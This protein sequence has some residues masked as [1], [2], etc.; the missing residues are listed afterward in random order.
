MT[1]WKSNWPPICTTRPASC[2]EIRR[3][4]KRSTRVPPG[5]FH[6]RS[7]DWR[8]L[9]HAD[10]TGARRTACP[11]PPVSSGGL[12]VRFRRRRNLFAIRSTGN[13][14]AFQCESSPWNR[15]SRRAIYS[16]PYPQN[17]SRN[18]RTKRHVGVPV[19]FSPTGGCG[20]KRRWRRIT[21]WLSCPPTLASPITPSGHTCSVSALAAAFGG[22]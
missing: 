2:L 16:R 11:F 17:V 14:Y 5:W 3:M 10:H 19:F 18:Y 6:R 22:G 9:Q 15:D 8:I 20:R 13:R 12:D 4:V 7:R 21:P 1:D